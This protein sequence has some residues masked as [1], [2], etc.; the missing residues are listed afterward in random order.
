VACLVIP[1]T[2][3]AEAGR[4]QV[5]GQ[6]WLHISYLKEKK[7][8]RGGEMAQIMYTHVNKCKNN[9]ILKKR[10]KRLETWLKQ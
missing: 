4:S 1:A 6:P 5:R 9:K 3:K 2:Q 8:K 10:K 7:K